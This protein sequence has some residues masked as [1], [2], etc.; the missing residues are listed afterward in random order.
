MS[1]S[2]DRLKEGEETVREEVADFL[3]ELSKYIGKKRAGSHSLKV[4]LDDEGYIEVA[5]REHLGKRRIGTRKK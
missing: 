3:E 2:D 1:I 5:I 4:V